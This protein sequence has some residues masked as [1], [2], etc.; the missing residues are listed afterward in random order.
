LYEI[1]IQGIICQLKFLQKMI[2][3]SFYN[4]K[5]NLIQYKKKSSSEYKKFATDLHTT[6]IF[7]FFVGQKPTLQ[8]KIR[9]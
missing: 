1:I 8:L 9:R 7:D 3:F 2:K 5:K 6:R 4:F